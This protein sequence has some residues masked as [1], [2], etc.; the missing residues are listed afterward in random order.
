MQVSLTLLEFIFQICL[1]MHIVSLHALTSLFAAMYC[2]LDG[3]HDC[4]V[5]LDVFS[6]VGKCTIA[7]LA[8]IGSCNSF[9]TFI[10]TSL[11]V[12]FV[13]KHRY[14]QCNLGFCFLWVCLYK[15]NLLDQARR[16]KFQERLQVTGFLSGGGDKTS[17][18]KMRSIFDV[19][20][21]QG[22]QVRRAGS[23]QGLHTFICFYIWNAWMNALYNCYNC[24]LETWPPLGSKIGIFIVLDCF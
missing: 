9:F 17:W 8:I 24:H 23:H 19:L 5:D 4:Y 14:L 10:P 12:S 20:V 21:R 11:D 15:F 13:E 18:C 6:L 22:L 1:M 7:R 2:I 16:R 3:S